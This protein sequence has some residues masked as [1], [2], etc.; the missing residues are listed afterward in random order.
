MAN[1]LKAGKNF[2]PVLECRQ[3]LN[4]NSNPQISILPTGY[5]NYC[6]VFKK[7]FDL[8]ALENELNA[9]KRIKDGDGTVSV[10]FSGGKDST[11]AL[12]HIMNTFNLEP[13]VFFVDTG[14][15]PSHVLPRAKRIAKK[16]GV[17]LH[18]KEQAH[19]RDSLVE[20]QFRQIV[21]YYTEKSPGDFKQEFKN[22]YAGN[23]GFI[24]ACWV[25][26]RAMHNAFYNVSVSQGLTNMVAAYN[27]WAELEPKV[28]GIKI[29][30]GNG[31][32]G[33]VVKM[34]HLP[35]LMRLKMEDVKKTI[36]ELGLNEEFT[37]ES[38]SKDCLLSRFSETKFKNYLGFHPDALRLSAEVISGFMTKQQA[39]EALSKKWLDGS[40]RLKSLL[41]KAV[42]ERKF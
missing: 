27:E 15:F 12:Y 30:K 16:F 33:T 35:F 25:C 24:R 40:W 7:N 8:S 5:C 1:E 26:M 37:I 34:F 20:N 39:K 42:F 14:Y 31:S 6:N 41:E 4:T 10:G 19:F 3:C 21:N 36:K 9:F 22:S 23:A 38:G 2:E 17:K 13:F 28:S 11:V 32:S 18:V 29:L